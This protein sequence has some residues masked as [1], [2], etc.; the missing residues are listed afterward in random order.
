MRQFYHAVEKDAYEKLTR[1]EKKDA[2]VMLIP[3]SIQEQL[4][5]LLMMTIKDPQERAHESE[6]NRL[7]RM[8]STTN[9]PKQL[10]NVC[11]CV[12]T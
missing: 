6:S 7:Q 8:G 1:V 4:V 12:R 10:T 3:I 9:N 5:T 2:Y 11:T